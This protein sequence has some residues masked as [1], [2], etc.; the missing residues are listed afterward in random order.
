MQGA[1]WLVVKGRKSGIPSNRRANHSNH[2]VS[3]FGGVED[4]SRLSRTDPVG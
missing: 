1:A 2:W 4:F 3:Y